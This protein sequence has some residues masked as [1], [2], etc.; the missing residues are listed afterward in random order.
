MRGLWL[1]LCSVCFSSVVWAESFSARAEVAPFIAEMVKKHHFS[2]AA[3]QDL[4]DTASIQ[5]QIIT[6][7]QR[8]AEVKPWYQYRPLFLSA[9]QVENGARFWKKHA[10]ALSRAQE[11]Y[12]VPPEIIIAII[13]V[14]TRYGA[15]IGS[16]RVIDA[17]STLAFAYPSREKFFKQ[18]LEHF[19][20]MTRDEH[21]DP[22]TL[23]GSYAGAMGVPQF[24]PSSYRNYAVDFSHHGQKDLWNDMDD[25]IGSVANYFA[26][27]G[28]HRGKPVAQKTTLKKNSTADTLIATTKTL[29][30]SHLGSFFAE[31]GVAVPSPLQQTK[32]TL[33]SLA[34]DD[35]TQEY[36]LGFQ[37]F[38]VITQYNKSISYAMAVFQLSEEI[39][40]A[41]TKI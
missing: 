32:L 9:T 3:L 6:N 8:P 39:R 10:A 4:F 16:Y 22:K 28:W 31:H 14:E 20:L 18:E 21:L 25:V 17:L 5:P 29:K 35:H 40:A 12:G 19:L 13:G 37:N 34:Q 2:P 36:W 27:N 24:M 30:P 15:N 26:K 33:L 7:M 23:K 1:L 11:V 38:Y 41:Y